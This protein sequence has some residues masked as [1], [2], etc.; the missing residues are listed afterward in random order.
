MQLRILHVLMICFTVLAGLGAGFV[1][2]S[3]W[4]NPMGQTSTLAKLTLEGDGACVTL[5]SVP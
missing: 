5:S 1:W 3:D 4:G 2:G